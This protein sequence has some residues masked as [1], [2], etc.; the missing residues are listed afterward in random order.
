MPSRRATTPAPSPSEDG[1]SSLAVSRWVKVPE[2]VPPGPDEREGMKRDYAVRQRANTRGLY[3]GYLASGSFGKETEG[4]LLDLLERSEGAMLQEAEDALQ[5]GRMP[6]APTASEMRQRQTE[7]DGELQSLLG[8]D[9]FQRLRAYQA[10]IPDQIVIGTMNE[11][12]ASLSDQQVTR[13]LAIM[14]EERMRVTGPPGSRNLDGVDPEL[15]RRI[16]QSEQQRI[17]SATAARL[18]G[19]LSRQ[20]L[21]T[22]Q[23]VISGFE[24][25]EIKK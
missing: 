7:I 11:A 3:D 8:F 16:V 18:V 10:S 15:S 19:L 25:P 24:V 23:E 1:T 6:V 5:Q 9:E 21:A 20:Q 13:T 4:R 2:M 14:A 22:F 17:H 12:G